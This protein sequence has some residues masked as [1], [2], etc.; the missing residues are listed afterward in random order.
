M[1]KQSN[2]ERQTWTDFVR[3]REDAQKEERRERRPRRKKMPQPSPAE[4]EAALDD[5]T[6]EGERSD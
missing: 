4:L 3:K 1:S 2:R 6:K 5:L